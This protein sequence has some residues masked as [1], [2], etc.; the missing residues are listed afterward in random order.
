MIL[1]KKLIMAKHITIEKILAFKEKAI[2]F[3]R[4]K[5]ANLTLFRKRLENLSETILTMMTPMSKLNLLNKEKNKSS[6]EG[7]KLQPKSFVR[8]KLNNSP[9][10]L[11]KRQQLKQFSKEILMARYKRPK[12][13]RGRRFKSTDQS[14]R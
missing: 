13:Q 14:M 10:K 7:K 9:F 5:E 4:S 11:H 6:K 8:P 1:N 2:T 12:L 3:Q